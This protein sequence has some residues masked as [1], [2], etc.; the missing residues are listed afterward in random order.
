MSVETPPAEVPA[1]SASGDPAPQPSG[2]NA[3]AAVK[4]ATANVDA[5][6]T[7]V[8][9]IKAE[10]E[11]ATKTRIPDLQRQL[12]TAQGNETKAKNEAMR[13]HN[14]WR[15]WVRANVPAEKWREIEASEEEQTGRVLQTQAARAESLE[16][17]NETWESGDYDF[18]RFLKQQAQIAR[19]THATLPTLK[20][21]Y[22]ELRG[23]APK[24]E[25]PAKTE[26]TPKPA[27][28]AAKKDPPRVPGAG[29]PPSTGSEP[30]AKPGDTP[31]S[32]FRRA[33]GREKK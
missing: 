2:E 9:R 7:E 25:T 14:S 11:T 8:E 29:A 30:A 33:F 13:V 4:E 28:T 15:E 19:V 5:A 12:S 24:A 16:V 22:A 18:A 21:M 23:T 27:T 1:A 17:I 6:T 20:T 3:P 26:E 32:L 31:Q 10:L